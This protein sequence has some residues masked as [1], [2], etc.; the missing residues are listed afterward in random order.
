M[1]LFIPEMT[2][3]MQAISGVSVAL[4]KSPIAITM[5]IQVLFDVQLAPVIVPAIPASFLLTYRTGLVPSDA[6]QA[7]GAVRGLMCDRENV[8]KERV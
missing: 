3:T 7:R 2:P 5:I 8:E 4:L 6:G 1:L